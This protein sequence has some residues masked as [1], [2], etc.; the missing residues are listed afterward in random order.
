MPEQL[1][2]SFVAEMD[3]QAE[4]AKEVEERRMKR[5]NTIAILKSTVRQHPMTDYER[6]VV[7]KGIRL[8]RFVIGWECKKCPYACTDHSLGNKFGI[9][10]TNPRGPSIPCVCLKDYY[11]KGYGDKDH[12]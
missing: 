11:K 3:R 12:E 7:P 2:L 9:D 8:A 4:E 5:A 10:Y 1:T 6:Q